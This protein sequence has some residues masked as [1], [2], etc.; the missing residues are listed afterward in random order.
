MSS[1]I[2]IHNNV[3]KNKNFNQHL[4]FHAFRFS[5]TLFRSLTTFTNGRCV[6]RHLSARRRRLAFSRKPARTLRTFSDAAIFERRTSLLQILTVGFLF[7]SFGDLAIV[8][9]AGEYVRR[10]EK[11]RKSDK[12]QNTSFLML[13]EYAQLVYSQ[14]SD[15]QVTD[16]Q[17]S[18]SPL[19]KLP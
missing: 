2:E 5:S 1:K 3:K 12:D 18:D 6:E 7:A 13:L 4:N 19:S 16:S 9:G 11:N 15:F 14:L 8:H 17:V 10:N